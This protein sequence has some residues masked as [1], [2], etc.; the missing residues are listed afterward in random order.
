MRALFST[1]AQ[2]EWTALLTQNTGMP[3]IRLGLYKNPQKLYHD[4]AGCF[5][6]S[7]VGLDPGSQRY[8]DAKNMEV[9]GV[10]T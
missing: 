7:R 3:R 6:A 4:I 8:R 5:R 1:I 9:S 2:L 10:P